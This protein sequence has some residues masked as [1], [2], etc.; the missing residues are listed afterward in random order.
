MGVY[1]ENTMTPDYSRLMPNLHADMSLAPKDQTFMGRLTGTNRVVAVKWNEDGFY[2]CPAMKVKA[3]I[4][5]WVTFKEYAQ[6]QTCIWNGGTD[7]KL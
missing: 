7:C 2:R 1:W 4:C 5:Q 3:E 6:I